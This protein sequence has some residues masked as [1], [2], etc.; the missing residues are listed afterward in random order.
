M[1]FSSIGSAHQDSKSAQIGPRRTHECHASIT[2]RPEVPGRL[3]SGMVAA[4]MESFDR[5]GG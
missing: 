1:A 4:M 2:V 3:S 5:A